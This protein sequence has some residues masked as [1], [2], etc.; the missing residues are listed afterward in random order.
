MCTVT[1]LPKSGGDYILTSNRDESTARPAALAPATYLV[2]GKNITFPKDP[3]AGGSWIAYAEGRAACLLNGAFH[4]HIPTP[5]YKKSRG[6]VVLDYF[7]FENVRLFS[8]QYDFTGIEPFTLLLLENASLSELRWDGELLHVRNCN[9][10]VPQI[11]SSVTLYPDEIISKRKKWFAEWLTKNYSYQQNAIV[12]FH[13]TAGEGNETNDILMKRHGLQTVS[14][15]S[16]EKTGKQL[17]MVYEDLS[18]P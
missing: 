17:A 9:P 11:W 16:I 1:Y 8:S 13:H 14:I 2:H 12:L 6:L 18:K 4:K 15:T 3:L 10:N 5:P 7:A